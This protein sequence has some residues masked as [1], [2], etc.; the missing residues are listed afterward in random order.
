MARKGAI[1]NKGG[2]NIA[3]KQVKNTD[4]RLKNLK[5]HFK[6]GKSGNPKG[7]PPKR[8]CLT[9][10]LKDAVQ[11]TCPQDKEKRTWSEILTERLLKMASKGDL[12]AMRLIFEYVE[13][14][15]KQEPGTP[16]E[17]TINVRYEDRKNQ[18]DD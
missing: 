4:K 5:P 16:D 13:G 2:G 17:V 14:K 10:L 12:R 3:D 7:R 8:N 9:S 18:I 6:P 15:P 11:E 1:L